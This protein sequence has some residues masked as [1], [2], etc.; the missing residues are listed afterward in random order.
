MDFHIFGDLVLR[1]PSSSEQ[2]QKSVAANIKCTLF[3]FFLKTKCPQEA[4]LLCVY[5][6]IY[7]YVYKFKKFFIGC[8]K[9]LYIS[10][11]AVCC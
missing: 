9:N 6:H 7:I 2:L 5:I 10:L 3:S 4:F 1:R 11:F 8:H